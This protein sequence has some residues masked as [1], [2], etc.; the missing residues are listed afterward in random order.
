MTR[1]ELEL[2]LKDKLAEVDPRI[3]LSLGHTKTKYPRGYFSPKGTLVKVLIPVKKE[4]T[5]EDLK[6]ALAVLAHEV[7]HFEVVA[8]REPGKFLPPPGTVPTEIEA[9]WRGLNWAREWGI[10]PEFI[11]HQVRRSPTSYAEDIRK[12]VEGF[13]RGFLGTRE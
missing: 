1:S 12:D 9:S 3:S 2:H 4:Y 5:E 7:G 13:F 11:E 6:E 10:F 8:G